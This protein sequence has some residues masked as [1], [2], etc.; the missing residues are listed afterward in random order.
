M[1]VRRSKETILLTLVTVLLLCGCMEKATDGSTPKAEESAY[2]YDANA[3]IETLE[4]THPLFIEE[5]YPESYIDAK[6][7]FLQ[8]SSDACDADTFKLAASKYLNSLNDAHT[9]VSGDFRG[10]SN[11]YVQLRCAAQEDELLLVNENGELTNNRVTMICGV[12][13]A[14]VYSVIDAYFPAENDAA[15][16]ANHTKLVMNQRILSLAGCVFKDGKAVVTNEENGEERQQCAEIGHAALQRQNYWTQESATI[17]VENGIAIFDLNSCMDDNTFRAA[18]MEL[19]ASLEDGV[20]KVI[21]DVRDN[22]GGDSSVC[23]TLLEMLGM[24]VPTYGVVIRFSPLAKEQRGYRSKSGLEMRSPSL[25]SAQENHDISLCVLINDGT[26]SSATMLA[27]WVQDGKLGQVVGYPS[28]NAPSSYGDI[29]FY[30]LPKTDVS[31]TISHKK[32][33]RPDVNANQT[34]L[35]PDVFV[36]YG[37]DALPVAKALFIG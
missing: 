15:L 30:T 19:G 27:V 6:Q 16:D 5:P 29:I 17:H 36:P 21:I 32:F 9:V 22:P 25:D 3:L 13:V 23:G 14:T 24:R 1:C 18:V 28:A 31:V 7:M 37:E 8:A 11:L 2:L 20:K 35:E 33:L 10:M 4:Q 12:P 26:F 34:T